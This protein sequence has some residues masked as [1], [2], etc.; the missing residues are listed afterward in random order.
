MAAKIPDVEKGSEDPA[1]KQEST[2]K[3][4]L[5]E[6]TRNLVVCGARHRF[7]YDL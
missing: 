1:S 2:R 4:S 3:T 7:I 5:L 6:K